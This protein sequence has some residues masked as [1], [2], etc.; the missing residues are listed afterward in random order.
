M[1]KRKPKLP[2]ITASQIL[3]LLT[4]KHSDDVF[5]PEC[6]TGPSMCV[7]HLRMDAWAMKRS[8]AHPLTISY[9]IKV[10]R[11]DFLQDYK[12]REYLP[13][14][15]QLFFVCPPGVI[16]KNELPPEAGLIVSSTN[17]TRLYTKKKA[18]QRD[19]SIPEELWRYILMH[20][21]A[22]KKEDSRPSSHDFWQ[23]WLQNKK[24]D[25]ELGRR[26][27]RCLRETI[28]GKVNEATNENVRLQ[29]ENASLVEVREVLTRLGMD[30]IPP[31]YYVERRVKA[32]QEVIPAKLLREVQDM[33]R[34]L[35]S[36]E[37]D[38]LSAIDSNATAE[39]DDG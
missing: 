18:P 15:N 19:V 38:L 6:K 32:M 17:G 1:A 9:E 4:V 35:Q 37:K 2:P 3:G 14:C 26:I 16:E 28:T 12:W 7:E 34:D 36:F 39:S 22:I 20:R 10:R 29:S 5:I 24:L 25:Y 21:T 23:Q 33:T 30:G 31:E 27:S 13:Y 11:S 8:W